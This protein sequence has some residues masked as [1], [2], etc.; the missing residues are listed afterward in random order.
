M[1]LGL[2][3]QFRRGEIEVQDREYGKNNDIDIR[4]IK[5]DTDIRLTNFR[6][7]FTEYCLGCL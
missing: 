7:H 4:F 6:F 3:P 2:E 1:R 5:S